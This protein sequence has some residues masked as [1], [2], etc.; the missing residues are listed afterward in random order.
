ML[1]N[2]N[3]N[4]IPSVNKRILETS[5]LSIM[6]G[7]FLKYTVPTVDA[8]NIILHL[9]GCYLLKNIYHNRKKTVQQLYL[10]HLS[11]IEAM[12]NVCYLIGNV[13]NIIYLSKYP[14]F[15]IKIAR[16][17]SYYI[18]AITT[19]GVYL[20]YFLAMTYL[21]VDR[22][23]HVL[24]HMKYSMF[25]TI[26]KA[27][28]L[29]I[30]TCIV[31]FGISATFALVYYFIR[32][33]NIMVTIIENIF[34]IY[35][36]TVLYTIF[37][38]LAVVSY[39]IMFLK[40]ADS[41]RVTM[42]TDPDAPRQSL[43]RIFLN[44]RF[45]VSIILVMSYLIFMIIPSLIRVFYYI[46]DVHM[47]DILFEYINIS[48]TLSDT[49]DGIIYIFMDRSVRKLLVKKVSSL[50]NRNAINE[51][52]DVTEILRFDTATLHNANYDIKTIFKNDVNE[53]TTTRL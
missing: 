23:L 36:P 15:S 22:L 12:K 43:F 52:A 29:L 18:M 38:I 13:S 25:W 37:V 30:V 27:R 41:R 14:I 17:I 8:I 11:T 44:S 40:F 53:Q 48:V 39:I 16:G 19:T 42:Q 31:N 21:T 2:Y 9:V 1:E 26:N 46:A 3:Y 10:I 49:A 6:L 20:S 35:V 34:N 5:N 33:D 47:P 24:L 51:A 28:K 7:I 32:D 50:I 4:Y 45:F